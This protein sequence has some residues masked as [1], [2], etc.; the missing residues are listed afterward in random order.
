MEENPMS[1][2]TILIVGHLGKE[3]EMRYTPSGQAVTNF[4]LAAN[5][6][7]TDS[8]GQVVKE[9]TWFRISAWGKTA[10]HCS[11]FLHKGSLVL[12]EGRM[13]CDPETGGPRLFSRKDGTPST[14]FEVNANTVRFLSSRE[15]HGED[16]ATAAEANSAEV[17]F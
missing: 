2:H 15:E 7:Y 8:S 9:T 5:R 6:Q 13:V 12:V 10:E 1:F 17:P 14:A 16:E 11:E 3:P 4:N